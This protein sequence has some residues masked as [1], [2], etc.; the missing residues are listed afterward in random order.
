[1]HRLASRVFFERLRQGMGFAV[2]I[3]MHTDSSLGNL[4]L[5]QAAMTLVEDVYRVTTTFPAQE[6]FGLT[7]M[8]RA[9]VS[10]EHRRGQAAQARKGT[11]PSS[12]H[13]AR[14][15]G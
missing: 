13:R 7:Q 1:M 9:D 11:R 3:G 8:R 4:K 2:L 6:R 15:A 10:V 5:W 12:R 14:V